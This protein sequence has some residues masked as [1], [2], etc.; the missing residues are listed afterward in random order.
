M[1]MTDVKETA[2]T[3]ELEKD[4]EC[5]QRRNN[6]LAL[7]MANYPHSYQRTHMQHTQHTY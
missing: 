6:S 5:A 4:T 7:T 3:N 2:T 1:C